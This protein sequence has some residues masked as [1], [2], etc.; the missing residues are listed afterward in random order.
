[1]AKGLLTNSQRTAALA[2]RR[3]FYRKRRG[4]RVQDCS[5]KEVLMLWAI[6]VILLAL[7]LLGMATLHALGIYVHI[8][9]VLAIIAVL[10]RFIQGRS[11]L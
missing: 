1:M 3:A 2:V 6:A 8:L 5:R 10:I 7:W 4:W 9:L 11:P